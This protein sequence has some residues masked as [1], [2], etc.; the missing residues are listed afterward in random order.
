[1][2]ALTGENGAVLAPFADCV[3]AV[4]SRETPRIQEA[5]ITIGHVLCEWVERTRSFRRGQGQG[6]SLELRATGLLL[7]R[8]GVINEECEYL[9]DPKDLVVIRRRGQSHRRHQSP[10]HPVAVVTN[11]AGIGRGMYGVEDYHRREPRHRRPSGPGGC[12]HRCLVFLSASPRRSLRVPQTAAGHVARAAAKDLSLDL[13]RS[14]LV[15]DK[16]SDLEAAR[17]AAAARFW[18]A[19]ATGAMSRRSS[20]S[21]RL[22]LADLVSDSLGASLPFL[23]AMF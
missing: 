23:E 5:H 19:L 15:G 2:I 14:V 9:H 6:Q 17:A 8:D 13:T 11:Q 4:P 7:D 1:L 18:F 21:R 20:G 10:G 3:I 12:A 22:H 16:V